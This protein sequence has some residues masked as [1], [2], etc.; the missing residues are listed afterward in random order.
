M[1]S[2]RVPRSEGGSEV[3]VKELGLAF[4]EVGSDAEDEDWAEF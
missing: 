1:L 4:L 2:R 3:A